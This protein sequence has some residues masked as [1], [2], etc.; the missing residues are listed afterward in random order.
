MTAV[1]SSDFNRQARAGQEKINFCQEWVSVC[2]LAYYARSMRTGSPRSLPPRKSK[3][4]APRAAKEPKAGSFQIGSVLVP[5]DFSRASFKAIDYA[6]PLVQRFGAKLHFVH[7]FDYDYPPATLAVMPLALPEAEVAR[8]A[9]RRLQDIAKKHHAAFPAEAFHVVKGRAYHAICE[10]ARKLE[11]DLIIATTHGRTGVKHLFL[12][13]TAERIVQHAPC[14]ILVVRE[15]EREFF[16]AYG[17]RSKTTLQLKKI[18]VPVDFS[19]CSMAGLEYALRFAK[20]WGAQ[21]VA[22]NCVPPS[23]F[24]AYGE[25]G[26]RDLTALNDYA[27]EAATEEMKELISKLRLQEIIA[28]G[29]IGDGVPARAICRLCAYSRN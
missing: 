16:H 26:R 10:L 13:S 15:H 28:R 29:V 3:R 5:L 27:Q 1:H 21:L 7:A 12:G 6:L 24:P 14:P 2:E 18:L 22:F 23:L 4:I 11:T 25:Y 9:K 8:R 20:V 17:D 19:G